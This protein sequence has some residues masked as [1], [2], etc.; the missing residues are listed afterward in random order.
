MQSG[1]KPLETTEEYLIRADDFLGKLRMTVA[2]IIACQVHLEK[3]AKTF[4][5]EYPEVDTEKEWQA[6]FDNLEAIGNKTT[7]YAE[8]VIEGK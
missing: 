8:K 5:D 2:V 1:R 4:E 3:C 7:K 6:V